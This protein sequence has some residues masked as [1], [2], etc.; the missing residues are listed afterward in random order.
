LGFFGGNPFALGNLPDFLNDLATVLYHYGTQ[1]PGFEGTGNWRWYPT[2]L[3]ASADALWVIAGML[4]L[5]G[6]LW[7]D[8]KKGLLLL[9]FPILYYLLI[10]RFVVRFERNLVPLLPFLALGGGYL[11]D[12]GTDW[13]TERLKWGKLAGYMLPVVGTGLLLALPLVASVSFDR[14]LSQTDHRETA[15]RWVEQ[16]IQPGSK[17]AIEHYSI[18][19]DY[20]RYQVEDVIRMGD[21]S[22][23]WYEEEGFDI[24]IISDGIWE[25]LRRQPE[26]YAD[27]VAVYHELST[28]GELLAEFVPQ[29]PK[30]SVAGYPTIGIYHFAPVRLFRLPK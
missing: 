16:H 27:E 12:A 10:S 23:D 4:G 14:A 18:P 13:L 28:S 3:L 7:R 17:I 15:G 9:S 6:L 29:P 1:H 5:L 21:H 22:V 24:L 11:L 26:N 30:I 8:W 2:I 25:V 19:F 20:D